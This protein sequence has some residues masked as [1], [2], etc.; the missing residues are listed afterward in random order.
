M[1]DAPV[2]IVTGASRGL[3]RAIAVALAA[4]GH[5]IAAVARDEKML[6]ETAA[7][8][9]QAGAPEVLVL[10]ADL[11]DPDAPARIVAR[12][13]EQLR[14]IDRLVNVAGDTRR[15]DFLKLTDE[16]HLSGFALKYHAAVRLC[17][18]CWP[19]L[20]ETAGCIVNVSG[21]GAMTPEAEFTIGGPVNSALLNLSKA[22]S[23]IAPDR[24]RVNS[25]CPGHIVTERLRKR[26]DTV[27]R[28]EGV[29]F[30]EAQEVLRQRLGITRFG[31]PE[32]VGNAVA[33]LCS[34]AARY[35]IGANFVVD[36]GATPGL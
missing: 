24:V 11:V 21:V 16:D 17:R 8:C 31:Q 2:A 18:A 4:D 9:R 1:P 30:T 25:L 33:W 32:D 22:L 23:R 12:V 10:P 19:H 20:M 34:D 29:S 36:G 26:I 6:E 14:R 27:A 15:G 5:A 28:E 7:A 13:M 35:V 3:G